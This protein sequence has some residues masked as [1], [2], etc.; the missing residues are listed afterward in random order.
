[1]INKNNPPAKEN[2]NPEYSMFPK[3]IPITNPINA[4]HA[5]TKLKDKARRNDM[6]DWMSIAKSPRKTIIQNYNNM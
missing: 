1:V 6:P 4:V 2:T 5:D 3:Q